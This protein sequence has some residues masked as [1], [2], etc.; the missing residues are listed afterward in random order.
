[1]S[2]S[3]AALTEDELDWTKITQPRLR[4]RLQNR[5]SQ[6]KHRKKVRQNLGVE[7]E[8][9]QSSSA[10]VGVDNNTIPPQPFFHTT[11]GQPLPLQGPPDGS[12]GYGEDAST[13][14]LA[15]TWTGL[16]RVDTTNMEFDGFSY[17]PSLP[18]SSASLWPMNGPTVAPTPS[19]ETNAKQGTLVAAGMESK[20]IVQMTGTD[21]VRV[22]TIVTAITATSPRHRMIIIRRRKKITILRNANQIGASHI[23]VQRMKEWYLST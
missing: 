10:V 13:S 18:S 17:P 19:W 22:A 2:M 8:P 6:R 7:P 16:D 4:K 23:R 20:G 9:G 1:M 3:E 21:E 15:N 5:V 11:E 14:D 12:V